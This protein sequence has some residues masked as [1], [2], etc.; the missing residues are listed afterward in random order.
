MA[1]PG[2]VAAAI[3]CLE[4]ETYGVDPP[5]PGESDAAIAVFDRLRLGAGSQL[6]AVAAGAAGAVATSSGPNYAR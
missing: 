4:R 5:S 6:V 1:T 3:R 2:E